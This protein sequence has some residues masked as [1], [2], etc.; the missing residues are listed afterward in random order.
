MSD[1]V[2]KISVSLPSDLV[3]DLDIVSKALGVSRSAILSSVLVPSVSPMKE[4]ILQLGVDSLDASVSDADV[5]KRYRDG[6][7]AHVDS[8]LKSL[9]DALGGE[10]QGELFNDK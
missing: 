4:I 2:R 5:V 6:S 1:K 9:S 10:V 8:L 3:N 7:K